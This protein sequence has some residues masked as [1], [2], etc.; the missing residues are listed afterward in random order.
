MKPKLSSEEEEAAEALEETFF[1][2]NWTPQHVAFYGIGTRHVPIYGPIDDNL[3]LAICSQIQELSYIDPDQPIY[4][5]INTPGGSIVDGLA[6]YDMCKIVPNPIVGIVNGGA[7]SAGL[8]ILSGCDVRV[9]CP[10]SMFFYHQPI[11][12]EISMTNSE[13]A[14]SVNQ[15]YELYKER[16]NEIIRTRAKINKRMW[17]KEFENKV[18]LYFDSE[19]AVEFGIVDFILPYSKKPKISV[20]DFQ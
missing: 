12:S 18:S 7:M 4:I 11:M 20:E 8:L 13:E 14:Q 10:N 6:I 19:K 16:C 3:S 2:G 1:A 15:L 17:K 9:A 5:S